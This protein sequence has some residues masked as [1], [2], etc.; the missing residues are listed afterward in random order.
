MVAQANF[1]GIR[2]VGQLHCRFLVAFDESR[3]DN[4]RRR[5]GSRP[6]QIAI[7]RNLP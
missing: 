3:G 6:I 2:P 5:F 7:L 1:G 4:D